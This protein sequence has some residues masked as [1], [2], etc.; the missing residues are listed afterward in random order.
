LILLAWI[1]DSR[2]FKKQSVKL[3]SGSFLKI[4]NGQEEAV[5][6]VTQISAGDGVLIISLEALDETSMGSEKARDQEPIGHA[7]PVISPEQ[8]RAC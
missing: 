1:R 2:L 3:S 4:T 6:K 8:F 7:V 5:Y